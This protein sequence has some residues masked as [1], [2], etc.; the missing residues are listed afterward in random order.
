MNIT[1]GQKC[2]A[3]LPILLPRHRA[4]R[5]TWW[6]RRC[7]R[8]RIQDRANILFTDESRFHL[9]SSDGH[10]RVY[11]RVGERYADACVVQRQSFG[12]GSVMVWGGITLLVVVAGN[13]TGMRYRDEIVQPYVI[14][15]IQAQANNV[16]FQQDNV[17][18]PV[19]RV[20]RD[21]LTQQNVD[22]LPWPAVSPDL[23]PIEHI[24]N[25][26][27]RRLRHLPN[28]PVALAKMGPVL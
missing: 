1:S 15:F 18:P 4:A 3:I 11:R 6:C 26:M 14:P 24:W 2:P 9:D 8:F 5:L 19:A 10:S 20:V 25:E 23:S 21:Y 27:E 7:L 13:L 22:L 17:R 28:Q 12:G 16:T